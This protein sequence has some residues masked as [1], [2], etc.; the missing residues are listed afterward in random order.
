MLKRLFVLSLTVIV[1]FFVACDKRWPKEPENTNSLIGTWN[2]SSAKDNYGNNI[3]LDDIVAVATILK[4]NS[5]GTGFQWFP[6]EEYLD[7]FTWQTNGNR[8][9]LQRQNGD[10]ATLTYL[11]DN[12]TLT[13]TFENG[14]I[15]VFTKQ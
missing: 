15:I 1:L 14:Y 8:M 6:N 3:N 12:N 2:L 10:S 5:D 9:T 7:S 13:L 4:F 11:I